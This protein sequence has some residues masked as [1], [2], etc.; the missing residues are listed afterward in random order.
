MFGFLMRLRETS[1]KTLAS[2]SQLC[3]KMGI[4]PSPGTLNLAAVSG[5]VVRSVGSK[6]IVAPSAKVLTLLPAST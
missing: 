1:R 2:K 6:V 5:L 4:Q 3:F